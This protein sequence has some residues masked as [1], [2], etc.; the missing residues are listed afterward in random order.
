MMVRSRIEMP[1]PAC[2]AKAIGGG[3]DGPRSRRGRSCPAG[4]PTRAGVRAPRSP[5]VD[6]AEDHVIDQ[7]N[8]VALTS[9]STLAKTVLL[10]RIRAVQN[11]S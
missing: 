8:V 7:D 9:N 10:G 2:V 1:R 6:Y 11:R 3:A 5:L 4:H